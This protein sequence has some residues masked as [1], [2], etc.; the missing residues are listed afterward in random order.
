MPWVS[1]LWI[2]LM[3]MFPLPNGLKPLDVTSRQF[4]WNVKTIDDDKENNSFLKPNSTDIYE[5]CVDAVFDKPFI[6]TV[7]V[8]LLSCFRLII[9]L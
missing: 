2:R 1:D 9:F 5:N 4:K 3:E 8:S 6:S 7:L